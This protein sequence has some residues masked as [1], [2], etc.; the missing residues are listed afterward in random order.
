MHD[1]YF[2]SSYQLSSSVRSTVR[3]LE[4]WSISIEKNNVMNE[5][6]ETGGFC[7]PR[8]IF[9]QLTSL[10]FFCIIYN[11]FNSNRIPKRVCFFPSFKKHWK[12]SWIKLYFRSISSFSEFFGFE[13]MW[14]PFS[15]RWWEELNK[16]PFSYAVTMLNTMYYIFLKTNKC[17]Q[18]LWILTLKLY[19]RHL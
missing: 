11:P 3:Y 2:C 7:T 17:K 1:K 10:N 16:W 8:D 5:I 19:N 6:D 4:R 12:T 18:L 14:A 9:C 15:Y 13:S